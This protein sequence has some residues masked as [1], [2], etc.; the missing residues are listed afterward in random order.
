MSMPH[1][2]QFYHDDVFLID[3][4]SA[5]IKTGYERNATPI[6]VATG[7]HREDLRK[8]FQEWGNPALV[9]KVVLYDASDL[10]STFMVEGWPNQAKFNASVGRIVEEAARKGP[11][12]IYGEMVA[13]LWAEGKTRAAIR[14][15]ELW[16]ELATRHAFSLLC[17]YPVSGF[18]NQDNNE[19]F[20]QVCHAHTHVHVPA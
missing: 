12:H 14:L 16:N 2:V 11:V 19:S 15:E 9:S 18:P 5:F 13:V 8:T 1:A 10:L 3:A 6:I 4:V 7:Q 20:Q 17:G